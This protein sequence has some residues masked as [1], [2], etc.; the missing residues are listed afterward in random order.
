MA[1]LPFRL[2]RIALPIGAAA[3]ALIVMRVAANGLFSSKPA[4]P[5]AP[6]AA[7][8]PPGS[9]GPSPRP[10]PSGIPS[11][12]PSPDCDRPRPWAESCEGIWTR[13]VIEAAGDV[14]V[15]EGSNAWAVE[16][17]VTSFYL[18]ATLPQD[19]PPLNQFLE[20]EGYDVH[21]EFAQGVVHTNGSRFV[22]EAQGLL[23]WIGEPTTEVPN[24]L[25]ER[26][27]DVSLRTP[28]PPL[29]EPQEP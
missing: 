2:G 11:P 10:S 1:E 27:L 17:D 22:W 26:L 18:W 24:A 15:G 16:T 6:S 5:V 21:I 23:V 3:A 4:L 29:S 19:E 28:Y 13:W 9:A 12:A 25:V 20:Q 7:T 8:S 14:V